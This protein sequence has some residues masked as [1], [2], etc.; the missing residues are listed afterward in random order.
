MNK[1]EVAVLHESH[2]CPAGMMMFLAKLTQRG[3][4]VKNMDDLYKLYN[5]SMDNHEPA[6][7]VAALPH[8]TIKRFAPI[9]IAI[10]GAS[11][12]FLAQART[13][14]VGV[15]YVS[16]SLQYSDYSDTDFFTTAPWPELQDR[17]VVPYPLLNNQEAMTYYLTG[18]ARDMIEYHE[19]I[20]KF[21]V[22]N[23][24]AGYK[25]PQ[26]MRNVLIMQANHEAWM[27]FIR[28]R[29]CHR[30]TVE[31]QYV[32]MLIWKE[33]LKTADGEEMFAWAG[34]DCCYG[35]CRE[36]KMSCGKSMYSAVAIAKTT[37]DALPEVIIRNK[38][39]L[40]GGTE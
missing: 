24:T 40:I 9:T 33:L 16:G 36:G 14:Q 20:N 2:E 28:A 22:D 8:G 17:F 26:G 13:H 39:P 15:T 5:S 23:D 10:V 12:R 19:L 1:I 4:S 38:W 31:T 37:M 30:N 11:R 7:S 6:R 3:H 29:G 21:G 32:T 18:C 27:N 25:A 35:Q 34:P